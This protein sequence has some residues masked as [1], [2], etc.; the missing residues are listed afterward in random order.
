MDHG[1][2]KDIINQ[3]PETS[4]VAGFTAELK[5][6]VQASCGVYRFF[7]GNNKARRGSEAAVELLGVACE[8][9][10]LHQVAGLLLYELTSKRI[11]GYHA[12]LWTQML[13]FAVSYLS[14]TKRRG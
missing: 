7:C 14:T 1:T 4:N 8:I 2:A 3:P 11:F 9:M 12:D 5:F 10:N 6:A 13:L